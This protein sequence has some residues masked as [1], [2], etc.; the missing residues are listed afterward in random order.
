MISRSN[1]KNSVVTPIVLATEAAT[2]TSLRA[3]AINE[4]ESAPSVTEGGNGG[5]TAGSAPTSEQG[6]VGSSAGT[7]S[8][9]GGKGVTP[10]AA[11]PPKA[12]LGPDTA[13]ST[14]HT[15]PVT[16]GWQYRHIESAS[17]EEN[18]AGSNEAVK[19]LG[20]GRLASLDKRIENLRMANGFGVTQRPM[21]GA[22]R[23]SIQE[24]GTQPIGGMIGQNGIEGAE[25][26]PQEWK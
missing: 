26:G 7:T 20:L 12:T 3:R 9:S 25:P 16:P 18:S 11:A 8:V 10:I 24:M 19:M 14:P 5:N 17:T 1:T 23:L 21:M 15:E 4:S 6:S 22:S 2:Q 13:S